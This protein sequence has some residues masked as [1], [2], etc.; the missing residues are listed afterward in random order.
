V[1]FT[2]AAVE[3][4]LRRL[5]ARRIAFKPAVYIIVIELFAP[6]QTAERLAH[7]GFFVGCYVGNHRAI[8]LIGFSAA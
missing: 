8:K 4:F 6:E 5:R 7:D 1:P 2:V 3:P